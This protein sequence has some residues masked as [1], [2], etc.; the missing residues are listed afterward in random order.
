MQKR[1]IGPSVC[2]C[3]GPVC[4]DR[5]ICRESSPGPGLHFNRLK[6]SLSG[7]GFEEKPSPFPILQETCWS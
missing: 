7:K 6:A 5:E 3:L 2:G 1:M 4:A